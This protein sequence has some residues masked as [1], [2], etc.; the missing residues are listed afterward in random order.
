M[1]PE[2]PR[3]AGEEADLLVTGLF[4]HGSGTAVARVVAEARKEDR[5]R[6]GW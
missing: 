2:L 5:G 6:I 4:M 1:S 3:D